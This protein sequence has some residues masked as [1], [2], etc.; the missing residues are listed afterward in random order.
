MPRPDRSARR[1]RL[2]YLGAQSRFRFKHYFMSKQIRVFLISI[3]KRMKKHFVSSSPTFRI[4]TSTMMILGRPFQLK[5]RSAKANKSLCSVRF[6]VASQSTLSLVKKILL[7]V[8]L[9]LS[10]SLAFVGI[11][12]MQFWPGDKTQLLSHTHIGEGGRWELKSKRA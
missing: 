5:I 11:S 10:L 2:C 1:A 8:L 3:I 6:A 9:S 4:T 7:W 12:A